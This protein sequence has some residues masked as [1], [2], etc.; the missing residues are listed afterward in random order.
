M[1]I[2]HDIRPIIRLTVVRDSA[3]R[4]HCPLAELRRSAGEVRMRNP[5]FLNEAVRSVEWQD[6][7]VLTP[8][9]TIRAVLLSAPWLV[10]SLKL[11]CDDHFVIAI[12]FS[13]G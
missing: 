4:S 6:I 7:R 3:A 2:S 1:R 9:Q 5:L 8:L 11:A 12:A 13:G 10:A